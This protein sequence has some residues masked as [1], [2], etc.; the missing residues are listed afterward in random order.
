MRTRFYGLPGQ[1]ASIMAAKWSRRRHVAVVGSVLAA[2][3]AMVAGWTAVGLLIGA[4]GWWFARRS[5]HRRV[6]AAAGA[7]AEAQTATFLKRARAEAVLFDVGLGDTDVDIVALG[8]IA[9]AIEVKRAAGRVRVRPDGSISAGGRRLPGR[10]SRQAIAA[11]ARLAGLLDAGVWIDPVVCVTDM[12]G[13][14]KRLQV[15]GQPVTVCA[16]A[17]L[18]R[19]LRKLPR[20]LERGEGRAL[21]ENLANGPDPSLRRSRPL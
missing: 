9:A 15:A 6:R 10:P 11:S 1:N 21:A 13:R 8:P 2:G 3:A 17:S 4:G 19:V 14:P 20:R 12:V 7:S 5:H 16:A 18:P